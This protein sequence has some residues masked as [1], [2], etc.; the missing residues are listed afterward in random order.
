M[1]R[2]KAQHMTQ[3]CIVVTGASRGIGAAIA[4]RLAQQGHFV[5]C[6][7]RTGAP[8][9]I[10]NASADVINH[11][12]PLQADVTDVTSLRVAFEAIIA[13]GLQITG[14]V[15]NAGVHLEG[16][17]AEISSDHW[18]EVLDTNATSVLTTSQV[19][20]PALLAAGGGLIVNIGS[21]FDKMGVKRNLAYCASKA[22][23]GAITRCLAVEWANKGIRVIDVAPGYIQTDLNADALSKGP[24]RAYLEKRIP[25][26]EPG[27]ADDVASLVAS[28]F[29]DGGR[30]LTGETIYIDGAQGIAH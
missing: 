5:A 25:A 17:S 1:I 19:A 4:H 16:P 20:Y 6:L 9:A 10:P 26:G 28:L 3:Q 13:R 22:A 15:N 2:Q 8:P 27:T 12:L 7:S 14:L 24:L 18:R 29:A 21:F 11:W 30:F 23:V